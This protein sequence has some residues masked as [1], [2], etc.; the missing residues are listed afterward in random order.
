MEELDA[1]FKGNSHLT[2][3]SR[4]AYKHAY[5]KIMGGLT[6]SVKNSTQKE[7]IEHIPSSLLVITFVFSFVFTKTYLLLVKVFDGKEPVQAGK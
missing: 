2:P 5:M 4:R 1:F 3:N 7:I 6:K